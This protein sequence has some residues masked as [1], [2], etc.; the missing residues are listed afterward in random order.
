MMTRS[1]V[2][3]G[4]GSWVPP[5]VV[6]NE[7]LA[8]RIDTSDEWITTRTGIRRRHVVS[9]GVS[10]GDLAVEAGRRALAAADGIVVDHLVLATAT[11]DR[12][13]PATAPDVASRLG[14]GPIPAFDISAVCTGFLYG[15]QTARAF[16]AAGLSQAV[17]LIGADTFST[18]LD[19][20]D[21]V[22]LPIFGDGAGAAVLRAGD[23]D[24]HG[25]LAGVTLHSDG[26]LA[27]LIAVDGGGA[28]ARSAGSTAP[29]YLRMQG[30]STFKRAVRHMEDV[31][32]HTL[33]EA[34]WRTD[35]VD[36]VVGHQANERILRSLARQLGTDEEKTVL[37]LRDV[38]NTAGASIPLALDHAWR[39]GRFA[40][41]DR[42]VM[43]AFGAG[44][45]WGAAA[46]TWPDLKAPEALKAPGE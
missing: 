18:Y 22:T 5:D 20:T 33:T 1:A 27:D 15:L 40:A 21:R 41:G 19:P 3:A 11:P 10:T 16:I 28:R 39:A 37:H 14:L 31:T 38:G 2:L 46:L 34:G 36:H 30:R 24:E 35:D 44:A 26:T 29:S 4:L 17:L 23:A 45:T 25:A 43:P 7:T 32:R 12:L 13:C 42:I 9:P 6:T 8:R